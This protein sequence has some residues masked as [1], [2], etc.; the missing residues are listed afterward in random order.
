MQNSRLTKEFDLRHRVTGAIIIIATLVVVIPLLLSGTGVEATIEAGR[1]GAHG[2]ETFQSR[3]EP[4]N[5][6][7]DAINQATGQTPEAAAGADVNS[8]IVM[9]RKSGTQTAAELTAGSA[10]PGARQWEVRVGTFQDQANVDK[11]LAKLKDNGLTARRR[12][13]QTDSGEAIRIW[14]GP[15]PQKAQAEKVSAR[16]QSLTDSKGYVTRHAS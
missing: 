13:I 4:L 2:K 15:Y 9:T 11:M 10:A 7:P 12:T 14:L 8:T 5:R 3:I 1:P 16:L 6:L